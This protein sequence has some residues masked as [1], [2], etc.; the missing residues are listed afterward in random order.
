MAVEDQVRLDPVNQADLEAQGILMAYAWVI[1]DA[2]QGTID[3]MPNPF[4]AKEVYT[5]RRHRGYLY[6][7]SGGIEQRAS[8]GAYKPVGAAVD[9]VSLRRGEPV[10]VTLRVLFPAKER[11]TYPDGQWL[12]VFY[13]EGIGIQEKDLEVLY[14]DDDSVFVRLPE[15][16]VRRML[17]YHDPEMMKRPRRVPMTAEFMV[18]FLE[19]EILGR[20][21]EVYHRH[22]LPFL[23]AHY[24]LPWPEIPTSYKTRKMP[25]AIWH[26][27]PG[28]DQKSQE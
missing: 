25:V 22:L 10:T 14:R 16:S 3:D 28:S 21:P 15:Q 20:I 24:F 9:F 11:L 6:I 17:I 13:P 1:Q 5:H 23:R 26:K 2:I 4:R 8:D 7:V 12:Y 19:K 27:E 18:T